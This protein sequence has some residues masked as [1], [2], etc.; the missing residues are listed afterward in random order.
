[1]FSEL[2][3]NQWVDFK[4]N[5]EYYQVR[6]R[7]HPYEM[8]CISMYEVKTSSSLVSGDQENHAISLWRA[9]H[10]F[11]YDGYYNRA[12]EFTAPIPG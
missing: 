10:R 4:R 1:V 5:Q 8:S 12:H 6:N 3:I 9:R 2:L 7:P 11:C